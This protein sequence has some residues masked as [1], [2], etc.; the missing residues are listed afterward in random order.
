MY[1]TIYNT[2]FKVKYY[3]IQQELNLKLQSIQTEAGAEHCC[4]YSS[5]DILAVCHKLY[6]DELVSVFYSENILDDK[7][8]NGIKTVLK[9]MAQNNDFNKI[10]D[11]IKINLQSLDNTEDSILNTSEQLDS[12]SDNSS[13]DNSSS[14][15]SSSDNSNNSNNINSFVG[16]LLF[17][18]DL[19]YLTHK[20][21]CQQLEKNTIDS[22]LLEQ[23]KE[24]S[25]LLSSKI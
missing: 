2:N 22:E 7:I 4:L 20:C 19:F 25:I 10:M 17:S 18:K 9:T 24:S 16:L 13:S 12:S 15:N 23:L 5:E 6:C 8:D 1:N 11:N 14:D 21:I 3:D